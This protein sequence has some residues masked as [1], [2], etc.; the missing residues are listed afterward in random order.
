MSDFT[1]LLGKLCLS[2]A[3]S[4][5]TESKSMTITISAKGID[6]VSASTQCSVTLGPSGVERIVTASRDFTTLRTL[7]GTA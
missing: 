5:P 7:L 2:L 3:G 1:Q 6:G 4:L